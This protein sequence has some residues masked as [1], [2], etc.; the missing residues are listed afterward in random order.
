MTDNPYIGKHDAEV[1][2]NMEHYKGIIDKEGNKLGITSKYQLECTRTYL[3]KEGYTVS[4]VS[5]LK[6][7]VNGI[8]SSIEAET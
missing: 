6:R 5:S 4:D 1:L 8:I 2:E 3:F 7:I